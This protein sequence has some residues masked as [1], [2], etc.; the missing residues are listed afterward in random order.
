M[1]K[2]R[3][4]R[5]LM[6]GHLCFHFREGVVNGKLIF[7]WS[8]K[9]CFFLLFKFFFSHLVFSYLLCFNFCSCTEYWLTSGLIVPVFGKINETLGNSPYI[10]SL[11]F[12]FRH[13]WTRDYLYFCVLIRDCFN[14]FTTEV[15][16]IQK[17]VH[18][19]T[20]KINGLVSVW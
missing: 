1:Y 17:P 9:I 14:F 13:T 11:I 18:W 20:Q 3:K 7:I 4:S 8:K 10:L 19:F 16:I 2:E 12:L 6:G 5:K 15:P